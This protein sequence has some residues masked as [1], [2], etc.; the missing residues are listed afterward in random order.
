MGIE[1]KKALRELTDKFMVGGLAAI[2]SKTGN[3]KVKAEITADDDVK[4]PELKNAGT[5]LN[6]DFANGMNLILEDD[7]YRE[8]I[9]KIS[10]Y[11]INICD[12]L[13]DKTNGIYGLFKV[14]GTTMSITIDGRHSLNGGLTYAVRDALKKLF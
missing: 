8:E 2:K 11:K 7:D 14:D 9:A 5:N 1:E 3:A 6:D 12:E 4:A 10:N 13:K